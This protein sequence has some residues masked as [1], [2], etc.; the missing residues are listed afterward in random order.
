MEADN[1]LRDC[2]NPKSRERG[3]IANFEHDT[4]DQRS[5]QT[6]ASVHVCQSPNSTALRGSCTTN[7]TKATF[8]VYISE[9][10]PENSYVPRQE[11]KD[12]MS[13]A[14]SIGFIEW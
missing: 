3:S 12:K 10:A 2:C 6:L 9:T 11:V 13:D 7:S 4:V 14:S 5:D 8:P 1:T